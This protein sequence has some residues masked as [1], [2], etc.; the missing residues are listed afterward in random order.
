VQKVRSSNIYFAAH[1]T[2]LSDLTL[3]PRKSVVVEAIVPKIPHFCSSSGSLNVD[4]TVHDLQQDFVMATAAGKRGRRVKPPVTFDQATCWF[5][6]FS[7]ALEHDHIA[8]VSNVSVG[9]RGNDYAAKYIAERAIF[10]ANQSAAVAL[11]RPREEFPLPVVTEIEAAHISLSARDI[12]TALRLAA[13]RWFVKN[14]ADHRRSAL[15]PIPEYCVRLQ[16][17]RPAAFG[18]GD[19][20]GTMLVASLTGTVSHVQDLVLAATGVHLSHSV[21]AKLAQRLRA[22]LSVR[23]WVHRRFVVPRGAALP[24]AFWRMLLQNFLPLLQHR[25]RNLVDGLLS[26]A[27]FHIDDEV[28]SD[29]AEKRSVVI[30]LAIAELGGDLK[31]LV[32]D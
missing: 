22:V 6:P 25:R 14:A 17:Q 16:Q 20:S 24:A 18:I 19:G 31:L 30:S 11:G 12:E 29:S 9:L 15:P 13:C 32:V 21:A 27:P 7:D 8:L 10:E 26:K 2:A 23:D 5:R 3:L 1:G 4:P 28:A